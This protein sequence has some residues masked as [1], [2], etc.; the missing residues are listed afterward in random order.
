MCR[1]RGGVGGLAAGLAS[2]LWEL[3]GAATP[4]FVVV[5]P[6]QADCLYQSALQGRA[7][8]A[9]GSVDSVM[10]GLACGATSP[11]AWRF[12]QPLVDGFLTIEDDAAVQAMR[13]L[14]AGSGTG[15]DTDIPVVAGES[16]AAG[17]AGLAALRGNPQWSAQMALDDQSRV[18]LVNTEGA[19]APSVYRELVGQGAE[20]VLQ[21]QSAWQAAHP[22]ATTGVPP[23]SAASWR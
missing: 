18:L 20:G 11:L 16:G 3:Q 15:A 22:A 17:L 8:T 14:A 21:R 4:R 5:E 23:A 6:V 13:D 1:W 7:A 2:Y 12:L 9:T 19:T 10:A